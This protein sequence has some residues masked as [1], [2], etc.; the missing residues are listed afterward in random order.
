MFYTKNE[1]ENLF[2]NFNDR[3]G[4]LIK[5]LNKS[6]KNVKVGGY[7]ARMEYISSDDVAKVIINVTNINQYIKNE[8]DLY[9]FTNNDF[10]YFIIKHM[11]NFDS[12]KSHKLINI[13]DKDTLVKYI[14]DKHINN[15]VSNEY[16]LNNI[17][18]IKNYYKNKRID[19]FLL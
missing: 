14:K 12:K 9:K 11:F 1:Y 10:K 15:D 2:E 5:L 13:D 19:L 4:V 18:K 3:N 7:V 17:L 8:D 16:I 6:E